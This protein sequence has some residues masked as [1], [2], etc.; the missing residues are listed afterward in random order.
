MNSPLPHE[1]LFELF[2]NQ[3]HTSISW[4]KS[5]W[6]ERAARLKNLK[7][8]IKTHQQEVRDAL[9]KDFAKPPI[10]VDMNDLFPVTSQI[11]HA[12]K[13][14]KS[15]MKPKKLGTPIPMIGTTAEIQPE[16]K[17]RSLI[18]SPWNFPFNLTVGP[19]VSAIAAGCPV[20]IKPSEYS[21]NTSLLIDQMV[22]EVFDAHQVSV[23]LGESEVASKLLG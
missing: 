14:L 11:N 23:C 22:R 18:I 1:P 20:I 7:T 5:T 4:R 10:E 3:L 16:P 19:L 13:N 17:G 12:L 21:P 6:E 15:W 8:W 2:E 9:W